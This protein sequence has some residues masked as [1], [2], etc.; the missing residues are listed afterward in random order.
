MG[1]HPPILDVIYTPVSAISIVINVVICYLLN[2]RNLS[3]EDVGLS[4]PLVL[5]NRQYWRI[6]SSCF[7]HFDLGH[8]IAN[9]S[10]AWICRIL[11]ITDGSFMLLK[12]IV[13]IAIAGSILDCI[14]R[15]WF[16]SNRPP[17]LSV[18]Y[19]GVICGLNAISATKYSYVNLFGFQIPWSIMPF[20]H[21]I[22]TSI[23]V[24]RASF[25]G[26]FA[27]LVIGFLISWRLFDW[28]TPSLFLNLLPWILLFFFGNFA[29]H[30]P[31]KI[32]WF[33]VTNRRPAPETTL[34]DGRI[35]RVP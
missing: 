35:A 22:M 17:A 8:I 25:I 5:D 15:K 12:Y 23:I 11:E 29:K 4:W 18:G 13:I 14:I 3:Y 9:V 16:M 26:H 30:N 10:S 19:S 21:I 20:I 24:P 6:I 2:S 33:S 31:E 28:L 7:S 27:G 32:T 1:Y 34:A